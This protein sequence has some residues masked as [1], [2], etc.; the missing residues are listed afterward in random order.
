MLMA[1][2]INT[3]LWA[4]CAHGE[5]APMNWLSRFHLLIKDFWLDFFSFAN[6]LRMCWMSDVG[7]EYILRDNQLRIPNAFCTICTYCTEGA[8][9]TCTRVHANGKPNRQINQFCKY[10]LFQGQC[11]TRQTETL[12]DITKLC[13]QLISLSA[14]VGLCVCAFIS[15]LRCIHVGKGHGSNSEFHFCAVARQALCG[16]W[17][18]H[19]T[20]LRA[21]TFRNA[22]KS[23]ISQRELKVK[24]CGIPNVSLSWSS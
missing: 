10:I 4:D 18:M 16:S 6:E 7:C 19:E 12:Y 11:R 2:W 5:L 17:H 20:G 13:M 14:A 15:F 21:P 9:H 1:I 24:K 23:K 3:A 22:P 8:A